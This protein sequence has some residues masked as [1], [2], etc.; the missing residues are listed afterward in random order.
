MYVVLNCNLGWDDGMR[1]VC[2]RYTHAHARAR[3]HTDTQMHARMY[4]YTYVCMYIHTY[5]CTHTHTHTH[6]HIH[7]LP[8]THTRTHTH[9]HTQKY[10][11]PVAT[12]EPE[13]AARNLSDEMDD[14]ASGLFLCRDD[15]ICSRRPTPA[16]SLVEIDVMYVCKYVCMYV[17]YVCNDTYV[18]IM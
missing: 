12:M 2:A 3:T 15:L 18:C 9:T 6:T 14:K 4:V 7:T 16:R 5:V 8:H 13:A 10:L 17:M 1:A 11:E